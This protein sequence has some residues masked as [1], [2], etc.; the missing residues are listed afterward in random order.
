VQLGS[1][2]KVFIR[3]EFYALTSNKWRLL[4]LLL[5]VTTAF[6][7]I[8]FSSAIQLYLKKK[9]DNPFVRFVTLTITREADYEA[10]Q[11][12]L[13][14]VAN[15][16][17][18]GFNKTTE[19]YSSIPN[20]QSTS[21][22]QPDAYIRS[23]NKEDP[24]YQFLMNESG[25]V[26]SNSAIDI[27]QNETSWGIIVTEAYLQKLGYTDLNVSYINYIYPGT[28]DQY[29]PIPVAAVVKQLPDYFNGIVSENLL[30]AINGGFQD[31]PL[32]ISLHKSE[33]CIFVQTDKSSNEIQQEIQ[34]SISDLSSNIEL[35][36]NECHL[37]GVRVLIPTDQPEVVFE[38]INNKLKNYNIIRTYYFADKPMPS[39]DL[40]KPGFLSIPFTILDSV[41]AFQK[42]IEGNHNHVRIDMNTIESKNNF[43]FFDKV[44]NLLSVLLTVF[45]SILMIAITLNTVLNHID[46][47]KTNL[48]TLKAFGMSNISVTAVYTSISGL[49]ILLVTISGFIFANLI[50]EFVSYKVSSIN[51]MVVDAGTS[52]F[53]LNINL[54]LIMTFLLIP[55][56]IIS[57]F[58]Y[59]KL[60]KK[61][62]GDLIYDRN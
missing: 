6:W 44:S 5:I 32:D 22:K 42:H 27:T 16:N 29:V 24:L 25:V 38:A 62:P 58:I 60:H 7:G 48:G 39:A 54:G 46:K 4:L 18:Y 55:I 56:F 15:Q 17:H 34:T 33:L 61:T 14:S 11:K 41:P 43:N 23:V 1:F 3:P 49:L 13:N 21:T 52:L 37:K 36:P 12:D 2:I 8:G 9:M 59:F 53:V 20:F 10:L 28:E 47:N 19:I 31:N 40:G 30:M 57:V 26:I 50:G 45:G 35:L 51:N